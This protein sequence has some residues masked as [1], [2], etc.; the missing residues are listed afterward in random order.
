MLKLVR[1]PNSPYWIIRGSVAGSRFEESTGTVDKKLAE[2]IR[3]ARE[4]GIHKERVY[5]KAATSTFAEAALSYMEGGGSKRFLLPIIDHFGTTPLAKIDL[6]SIE[7]AAT[8]LFPNGS[9]PTRNRQV[10]TPAIAVI[11]HGAKRGMCAL[12]VIERPKQPKGRI[13]WLTPDEAEGLI[14]AWVSTFAPW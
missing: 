12:P 13:R 1:R 4:A 8:K 10:F 9:P 14:A 7:S 5:G 11:R 2:E 3:S 6:A